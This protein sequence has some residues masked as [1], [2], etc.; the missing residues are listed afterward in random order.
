MGSI[1]TAM[2]YFLFLSYRGT[3][4]HGWQ[5]QKN[6]VGIQEVINNALETVLGKSIQ[7]I[8]SGRTDTGVHANEQVLHFDLDKEVY[9]TDFVYKL[10]SLLP[11]DIAINRINEVK[12][13]GHARFSAIERKYIYRITRRKNPFLQDLAYFFRKDLDLNL[14]NNLKD[15]MVEFKDF[16]CFSRVK[17]DVN[18]F[19]CDI[20]DLEW[21]SKKDEIYFSVTANR[22]LRG[23]VRAIV[24]TMIEVGLGNCS[25]QNFIDI[26]QTKDRRNAGSAV[27]PHGL[28][29]NSVSYPD[30][31]F[32]DPG[33]QL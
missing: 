12:Q 13:D 28:F 16:Q 23:M 11:K 3:N 5:V 19:I 30:E 4:Y 32:I 24:G 15:F 17:T 21:T 22:F 14:M 29:L 2:R 18:N 6:A 8:G 20:R 9:K 31:I 1:F 25:K 7:T 27:P 33:K 26:V 10:N